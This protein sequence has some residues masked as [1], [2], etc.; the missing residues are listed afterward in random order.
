[1]NFQMNTG[2]RGYGPGP[3][4]GRMGNP[5][6]LSIFVFAVLSVFSG[7]AHAS[8]R[9][10]VLQELQ[11]AAWLGKDGAPSDITSLA[12]TADGMLWLG[13]EY[14]LVRFDGARF[15]YADND[16]GLRYPTSLVNSIFAPRDGGLWI[17]F[18][19]GTAV[20]FLKDGK[21]VSYETADARPLGTVAAFAKDD[22]QTL[23]I[24]AVDGLCRL[25]A[26][27]KVLRCA[28][29]N[30]F[31]AERPTALLVGRDGTVW[32]STKHALY[33]RHR[34]SERFLKQLDGFGFLSKISVGSD[35]RIWLADAR[36]SVRVAGPDEHGLLVLQAG[37]AVQSA[38]LRFDDDGGLWI[39]TLGAGLRRLRFPEHLRSG[40]MP[41]GDVQLEHFAQEDGLSGNYVWPLLIGREGEIWI[42]TSAG[43]DRFQERSL[44]PANF[45]RGA[46]DFALA[47]GEDDAVWAGTTNHSLMLL[48]GRDVREFPEVPP[49]INYIHRDD[50]GTVWIGTDTAI[51]RVESGRPVRI[52]PLPVQARSEQVWSI[53]ADRAKT[54]WVVLSLTGIYKWEKEQWSHEA[55]APQIPQPA[56]AFAQALDSRGRVW[57]SYSKGFISVSE[58]GRTLVY[59]PQDGLSIGSAHSFFQGRRYMWIGAGKGLAF[60]DG[61]RFKALAGSV[62]GELDGIS[63]IVETASGD[64]WLRS[65]AGLLHYDAEAVRAAIAG[66]PLRG[67]RFDYL[68]GLPGQSAQVSPLPTLIQSSDGRLWLATGSGVVWIDPAHLVRDVFPTRVRIES[69]D[70][71]AQHLPLSNEVALPVGLNRVQIRYTATALRVPQRTQFR[72]RLDGVDP[73]WQD[74]GTRREALYNNL[75]P[76]SYRF[77]VIASNE[78]GAWNPAGS[79]LLFTVPPLFYQT[80][81]F[82]GLCALT[83][84]LLL[85]AAYQVRMR[86]VLARVDL[87]HRERLRERERIARDLHDTLLQSVHGLLLQLQTANKLLPARPEQA[88]Q[89]LEN[90]IDETFKAATEG[91]DTLQGLRTSSLTGD[92][93]ATAIKTLGEDLAGQAP[94]GSPTLV[95]VDVVGAARALR[96]LVRDEI[97]RIGA[98]ALRNAFRY[99]AANRIEVSFCYDEPQLVLRVRDN[100]KGIDPQF[101]GNQVPGGHYGIN[102]MRERA[103]L[104]G[105][106]LDVWTAPDAGTEV[107]FRI[108]ASLAYAVATPVTVRRW[109]LWKSFDA[110]IPSES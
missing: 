29:V 59:G 43:I 30:G 65:V 92:D 49:E 88:K 78:D 89:T 36:G 97:Y 54:L 52:A 85:F 12:Q 55:I 41:D 62:P 94:E 24:A 81:W 110:G 31:P 108:A 8:L 105:G 57:R 98:E 28:E 23:W 50:G 1:L 3:V 87:L 86:Y 60:F 25:N 102:G 82:R 70:S 58:G 109:F 11:H 73:D 96:P 84:F 93:L 15:S 26:G 106:S 72:Y 5:G 13:T 100:G 51:Y 34:G 27:E 33:A 4:Y 18:H 10:R 46:H 75:R 53:V 103:K 9:E 67:E 80:G 35:G 90:A 107:E 101:L 19:G 64:L 40:L 48:R 91:R 39:A 95:L 76:G 16:T 61:D 32:V 104:I 37:I 6:W 20:V 17:G 74:A 77:Q 21:T 99:A 2:Q 56:F 69:L 71:G 7:A 45:P 68:D 83:I 47:A 22:E 66:G 42:G 79:T 38:D 44:V 63:G 14:G